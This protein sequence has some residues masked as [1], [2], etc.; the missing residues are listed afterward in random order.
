MHSYSCYISVLEVYQ[1]ARDA[2]VAEAWL[3]AQEPYLMSQE[4]GVSVS[5]HTLL[6]DSVAPA[7]IIRFSSGYYEKISYEIVVF[8]VHFSEQYILRK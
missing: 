7:E 8:K 2:A 4:L 6:D 3:I 5:F 1:F